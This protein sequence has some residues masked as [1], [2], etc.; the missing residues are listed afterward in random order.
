M[1]A[2]NGSSK[3]S[4]RIARGLKGKKRKF[5]GRTEWS[6]RGEYPTGLLERLT[7]REVCSNGGQGMKRK[8]E[9]DAQ[10]KS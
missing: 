6:E 9:A 10:Q 8:E 5:N 7:A 2:T 4:M 1:E 3:C